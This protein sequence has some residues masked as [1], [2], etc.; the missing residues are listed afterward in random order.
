MAEL[1]PHIRRI[2]EGVGLSLQK[3]SRAGGPSAGALSAIERGHVSITIATLV[4]LSH[5]MGM[6]PFVVLGVPA[7]SSLGWLVERASQLRPEVLETLKERWDEVVRLL[8][9][10]PC[11]A[12]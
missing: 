1:G 11:Q 12:R 6:E 5:A 3:V 10:R 2:R 7:V 8:Q 4:K 9:D